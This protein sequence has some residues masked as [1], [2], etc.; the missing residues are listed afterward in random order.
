VRETSS[1]FFCEQVFD[2]AVI[3][4]LMLH[5]MGWDG[6]H[7]L[8]VQVD[9]TNWQFGATDI[10]YLVCS[11]SLPG[12]RVS[13]PVLWELLPKKGNSNTEERCRLLNRLLRLI[14]ADRIEVFL[15][16]REF[17]GE[18]WFRELQRHS[19]PYVIRL[20]ENM[21]VQLKDSAS[22]TIKTMCHGLRR[23]KSRA[24]MPVNLGGVALQLKPLRLPTGELLV[25]ACH[26]AFPGCPLNLYRRRWAI[27]RLFLCLKTRGFNL[28]DTHMTEPDRLEKLFAVVA[29]AAAWA[30]R[31]G[32][33]LPAPRHKNHGYPPIS[34][35]TLG[36][37][38]II[39]AIHR[40]PDAWRRWIDKWKI[41]IISEN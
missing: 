32:S 11:V 38:A 35:F 8:T 7:K 20:R 27:E 33:L 9:R 17:V 6:V 31:V 41:T 18:S 13:I 39:S 3:G 30:I 36:K 12:M 37:N 25:V 24:L 26:G 23:G 5:L 4:R 29:M 16:D 15:A 2:Y 1:A 21:I 28:E 34:L 22:M 14:P 19:I 10:N 40:T